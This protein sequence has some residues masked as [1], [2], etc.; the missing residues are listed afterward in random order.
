VLP[1]VRSQHQK[2]KEK[3]KREKREVVAR[4]WGE[5]A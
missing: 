5:R 4:G 3:K 2:G 1:I